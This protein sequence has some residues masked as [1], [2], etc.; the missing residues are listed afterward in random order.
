MKR[1]SGVVEISKQQIDFRGG[2]STHNHIHVL[3]LLVEK[4]KEYRVPV[5]LVFV[6]H[7]TALDSVEST[8][9]LNAL[10]ESVHT[11]HKL[12]S[13]NSLIKGV[14]LM[15]DS[16]AMYVTL[17]SDKVILSPDALPSD[18]GKSI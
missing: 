18:T 3:N 7:H 5:S 8:T 1:T 4:S 11:W 12:T 6:D 9:V 16:S 14:Q 2:Y 17:R 10:H 15:F 13:S